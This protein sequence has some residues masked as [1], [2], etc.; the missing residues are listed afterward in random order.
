MQ[1]NN[2]APEEQCREQESLPQAREHAGFERTHEHHEGEQSEDACDER[3]RPEMTPCREA[4]KVDPE[5]SRSGDET[6]KGEGRDSLVH[7]V[8]DEPHVGPP[9]D[10]PSVVG[11]VA[12]LEFLEIWS[13]ARLDSLSLGIGWLSLTLG[14]ATVRRPARGWKRPPRSATG[15]GFGY[16]FRAGNFRLGFAGFPL[17]GLAATKTETDNRQADCEG[18]SPTVSTTV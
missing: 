17:R 9:L 6:Q 12:Q 5:N 3:V 15:F 18:G 10:D 2:R 13:A 14:W 4:A 8:L 16:G 11:D 1:A 7:Q